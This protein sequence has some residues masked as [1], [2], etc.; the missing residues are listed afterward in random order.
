V[1]L[2]GVVKNELVVITR[3]LVG[4]SARQV[5]AATDTIVPAE[6]LL[7]TVSRYILDYLNGQRI[8]FSRIPVDMGKITAFQSAV[9]AAARRIPYGSTRSYSALAEM[10]GYPRAVR[11]A[12][13]VMRNNRL[14]LLIP[15]HRVIRQDGSPGGYCGDRDGGDAA[16]KKALLQMESTP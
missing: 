16:I 2:Y 1:V 6:T 10:A 5:I 12:A 13:S 7:L 4:S 11:A 9:L 3:V 14:P 8:D 15:C